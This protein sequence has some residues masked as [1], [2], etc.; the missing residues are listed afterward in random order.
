M[1]CRVISFSLGLLLSAAGVSASEPPVVETDAGSV[2][3][4]ALKNGAAAFRGIPYAVAPVGELRW[5]PTRPQA[6]W[7][8]VREASAFGPDCPQPVRDGRQAHPQSEDCLSLNVV[9]PDLGASGLPVLVSIHGGAF[10]VGSG[11]DLADQDVSTIVREGVVL[12][13]PNYR[14]GRLGFFA[15]PELTQEARG[16]GEDFANYWLMDQIAALHWVRRNIH[17]FGGDPER[18]TIL[19]CSAG[20]SS[21]NA[22]MAAEDARGLFAGASARSG[23][24]FFN[25]TRPLAVAEEQGARF[26]GT[27][28]ASRSLATLRALSA[29][30]ILAL[31]SGPPDFGAVVDGRLLAEPTSQAFTGGRIAKV[32]YLVGSTS[33][34]ASVFG[35]MGFDRKVLAERFGIDLDALGDAYAGTQQLDEAELLR[36]VQTDFIF[37]SAALGMGRLASSSGAPSWAYHFDY[38]RRSQA[39]ASKGAAHCAD[40]PYSFGTLDDPEAEDAEIARMMQAYLLS[41]IRNGSP[42][43]EGLPAWPEIG[44]PGHAPLVIGERTRAEPGFRQEQLA[45]WFERWERE[46]GSTFPR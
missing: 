43:T 15:H 42:G 3:G 18:V 14:L 1:Q 36:Q 23:G 22:L 44:E 32:P 16:R 37:T 29:D 28:G 38:V 17:R 10:F 34:E 45:T 33:D 8:G 25:A 21:I 20:G 4:V 2:R 31:E 5:R 12:V 30:E 39:A 19:G 6:A 40:M 24:G 41:F 13:S 11:R 35:L 9:T 27:G 26:A 46:N 7:Q